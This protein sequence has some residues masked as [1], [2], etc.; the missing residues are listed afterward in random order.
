LALFDFGD[1]HETVHGLPALMGNASPPHPNDV[2]A[3]SQP[4]GAGLHRARRV[5]DGY[6]IYAV[7]DVH[8]QSDLLE[9]MLN[10]IDRSEATLPPAI[11]IEIFMG[12]YVDRGPASAGVIERLAQPA[13]GNRQRVCLRGNHEQMMSLFLEDPTVL[14][15]WR[16]MGGLDTLA[17]YGIARQ[18][19]AD[20]ASGPRL[21]REFFLKV[22]EH[23]RKF[24]RELWLYFQFGDYVFV[25]AGLRPG[26]MFE[27]QSERDM[28]WIRDDF[29]KS[30]ADFGFTVVHGHSPAP[31][32]D[33]RPNRICVDTGA[34]ATRRLSCAVL[35]GETVCVLQVGPALG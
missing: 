32:V 31:Q 29:L 28:L 25:H 24:L 30:D 16:T 4:Q 1:V 5:P 34:Y 27:Q 21:R 15:G 2:L 8:G 13:A 26:I 35:E 23:H 18:L 19:I 9:A 3:R 7:G 11:T 10:A 17:S 6:R 20:P 22:P 12:D 14:N 33:V